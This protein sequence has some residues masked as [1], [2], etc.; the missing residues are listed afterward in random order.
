[1]KH[2]LQIAVAI[3]M[4]YGAYSYKS[5]YLM[6]FMC[7]RF[8]QLL[9]TVLGVAAWLTHAVRDYDHDP[10]T[11]QT[12]DD[13]GD[14]SNLDAIESYP[15][16]M[17]TNFGFLAGV[18]FF[19]ISI[20]LLIYT[21]SIAWKC[22]KFILRHNRENLRNVNNLASAA[23]VD[24]TS[25]WGPDGSV[26]PPQGMYMNWLG[27]L[28]AGSDNGGNGINGGNAENGEGRDANRSGMFKLPKY[29]EVVNDPEGKKFM[30]VNVPQDPPPADLDTPVPGYS[31]A[32]PPIEG[33][34][35]GQNTPN[36]MSPPPLDDESDPPP[37][38]EQVS[39]RED[40]RSGTGAANDSNEV[41]VDLTQVES[42]DMTQVFNGSLQVN[43]E[44]Q[45]DNN[46][47]A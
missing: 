12:F 29:S 45:Q 32:P 37:S 38:Y 22:Y 42:D 4:V 46:S 20:N 41:V 5:M 10:E 1:L 26:N 3:M 36:V 27:D 13:Y 34:E 11:V 35:E 43:D 28:D 18:L 47:V 8:F 14:E 33:N 44:E 40:V 31:G 21:L 7:I 23:V 16:F 6:P 25:F 39:E 15:E 9:Q 17:N 2:F 19:F 30:I 24:A